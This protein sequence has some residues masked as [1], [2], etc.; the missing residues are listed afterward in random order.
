MTR[1]A[2]IGSSGQLGSELVTVLRES[3]RY[4]VVP[5]AH[6]DIEVAD[7]GS[8]RAALALAR[9]DVVVNC[10]AFVRV[11]D[12]EDNADDALRVN[13]LGALQVARVCAELN[14]LCAYVSTDYVFD[15]QKGSP[16]TEDDCPRPVNVYGASKLAGEF[17]VQQSC[18]RWLIVRT[19]GLF[20]V[21]GARGKGGNFV[22]TIITRARRRIPL[23]VVADVRS[24][25]TYARDMASGLERLLQHQTTGFV[26][27]AN[28]GACTWFEFARAIVDYAGLEAEPQGVSSEEYSCRARRPRDSA[29]TSVRAPLFGVDGLRR[30]QDALWAYLVDAG[31]VAREEQSGPPRFPSPPQERMS[32]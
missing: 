12:A 15:G 30:W 24:S 21:R 29:L 22:E 3:G 18:Q 27:L 2:V 32:S 8:T 28:S 26:H 23:K 11:D 7:S 1:V 10:A 17:L 4:Q 9:P 13:A 14:A 5:L 25:P 16:Y 19:A 6:P 20:G 31:H